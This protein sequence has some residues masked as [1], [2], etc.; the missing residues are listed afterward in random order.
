MRGKVGVERL[1]E[2][3]AYR[4]DGKV[5]DVAEGQRKARRFTAYVS[6]D[7]KYSRCDWSNSPPR[8]SRCRIVK[9]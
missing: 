6:R 7:R 9:S 8:N 1:K 5:N 3:E 4:D 2:R